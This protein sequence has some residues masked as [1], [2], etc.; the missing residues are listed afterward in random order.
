M[1]E[2]PDRRVVVEE[3]SQESKA[4]PD[5]WRAPTLTLLG[6]AV[7]LT[8]TNSVGTAPDGPGFVS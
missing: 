4:A 2:S 1:T 5:E 3:R 8:L 6:D 7:P